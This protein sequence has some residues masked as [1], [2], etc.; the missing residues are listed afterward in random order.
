M[1]KAVKRVDQQR[2]EL[3]ALRYLLEVLPDRSTIESFPGRADFQI[4]DCQRIYDALSAAE[5]QADAIAAV[6]A[7]DLE[8][9]DIESFLHLGGQHYYTYPSLVVQRGE[10]FR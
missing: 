8:D 9:T 1:A 5:T 6:R 7:L 2:H 10:Q 4:P 3:K